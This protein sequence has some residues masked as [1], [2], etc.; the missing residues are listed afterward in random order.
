MADLLTTDDLTIAGARRVLH[1]CFGYDDFRAGQTLAVESVLAGRDT[2]VI[3]PTGGGKSLCFQVPALM[4]P[5]LTVVISPLISLM[6]DQVDALN[7]RGLPA[8]FI[9]S[10]LSP[11]QVSE[12]MNAA[13]EG[14]LKLLYVA[15]E[16]FDAGSTARQLKD[17][18]VSL[19]A[20][21]EAHCISQWGHDF[22]PSYLRVRDVRTQLGDPPTIA[23]TATA[24]PSVRQDISEQLALNDPKVIITGF[25]RTNLSYYVA[26]AKNDHEKDTR[27]VS[28]LND[29]DGLAVIYA[30]TRKSVER[31]AGLL[32][33]NKIRAA[34]YHAGLDDDRRQEVQESFMGE[35]V[36]AIVATNAF[37]MG[38]DKPNVRLVIH[39]SMPGT[40]E[41][42][43]QEAG[44]AGRDGDHSSVFLLHAF[45]DRFTHEFFIKGSYPEQDMVEN[46]YWY[47]QRK[48]GPSGVVNQALDG[49]AAGIKS[50][51][52]TARDVESALRVLEQGGAVS[53]ELDSFTR[54]TVRLLATPERIRNEL[55]GESDR[56]ELQLLRRLWRSHGERLYSGV[57]VD[58]SLWPR[59][60]GHPRDLIIMLEGLQARQFVVVERLGGGILLTNQAARL[61][62]FPI[63]W[64]TLNRRRSNDIAKLEA[65]QSYAY[66]KECRRTFVLRYFGDRTPREEKCSACDNCL[67]E[68]HESVIRLRSTIAGKPGRNGASS[69]GS[70]T[71]RNGSASAQS[72]PAFDADIDESTLSEDTQELLQ[73]LKD[74]RSEIAH[75]DKVPAYIVFNN[76][77]ILQMALTK[78]KNES[79]L[80]QLRGVGPAK[81][82][83]Y[84]EAFLQAIAKYL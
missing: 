6:K 79:A 83:K 56:G 44:R 72:K 28:I 55:N 23:L 2:L 38:I 39:H 65:M 51:K 9:N 7:R 66:A 76:K 31:I 13:A 69:A 34:A 33:T 27:L 12:R 60:S 8:A 77:T 11:A 4:L 68:S 48:A 29:Y 21:D 3:L 57:G 74:L 52:A 75:D 82:A 41:A 36:R 10:T 1:S 35:S 16:R 42:Y 80:L 58:L 84:G 50:V 32:K 30:S 61:E 20:I 62:A 49:I 17:I 64:R 15:P 43:Y 81:V 40:L 24:T 14:K 26:P 63:D 70:R 46:V 37:G 59:S 54:V 45:P 5:K 53:R 73:A 18:G 47:L 67:G 25:D 78:P 71:S 19:L 22:R